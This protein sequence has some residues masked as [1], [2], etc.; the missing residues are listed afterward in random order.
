MKLTVF[1]F[2]ISVELPHPEYKDVVASVEVVLTV[3]A[4]LLLLPAE[5]NLITGDT[6][7]FNL[8]LVRFSITEC[9]TNV[10]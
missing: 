8:Y 4:N 10:I 7:S 3:I 5:A 9:S 2:K 6:I 1:F